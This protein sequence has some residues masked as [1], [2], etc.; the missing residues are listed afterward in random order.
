MLNF[1]LRTKF[2]D[3]DIVEVGSVDSDNPFR[4]AVPTYEVMLHK[5][6][7]NILSAEAN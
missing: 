6:G 3:H 1:E 4:D 2:N 5:P 7:Y